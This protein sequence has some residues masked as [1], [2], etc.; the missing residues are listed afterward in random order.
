[1][2]LPT[3]DDISPS[4]E[5]QLD[6]RSAVRNFLG[7]DLN[8]AVGLFSNNLFRHA[9]NLMWMGPRAFQFYY[10]AFSDYIRTNNPSE[11]DDAVGWFISIID[12]QLKQG[13]FPDEFKR[14][15]IDDCDFCIKNYERFE[16]DPNIYGNLLIKLEDLRQRLLVK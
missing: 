7:K 15:V 13:A 16:I 9:E 5:L 8:Q 2:D 14:L 4:N 6:E 11:T 3:R 12:F 1:M 10:R